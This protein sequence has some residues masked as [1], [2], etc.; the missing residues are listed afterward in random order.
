MDVAG[1]RGLEQLRIEQYNNLR[2]D[3]GRLRS[4]VS[5][6]APECAERQR[7]RLGTRRRQ[8]HLEHWLAAHQQRRQ[9]LVGRPAPRPAP[10]HTFRLP[11]RRPAG[12]RRQ[13][14][15]HR[16]ISSLLPDNSRGSAKQKN[17]K[18]KNIKKLN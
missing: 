2:G 18:R 8:G 12:P 6:A 13:H 15:S 16:L 4:A 14:V 9:L 5:A 7:R 3:V 17:S 11:T 1:A 10:Q